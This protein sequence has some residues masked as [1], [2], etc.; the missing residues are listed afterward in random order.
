[1]KPDQM[2]IFRLYVRYQIARIKLKPFKTDLRM[3]MEEENI[4][5]KH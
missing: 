3:F 1:M 5:D 2:L 4:I